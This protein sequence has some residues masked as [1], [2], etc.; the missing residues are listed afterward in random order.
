MAIA[1]SR[2]NIVKTRDLRVVSSEE[3][4]LAGGT[5]N[6]SNRPF[7]ISA[8]YIATRLREAIMAGPFCDRGKTQKARPHKI[9]LASFGE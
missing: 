9:A 6:G 3:R 4:E 2:G 5:L 8:R 7:C 1:V